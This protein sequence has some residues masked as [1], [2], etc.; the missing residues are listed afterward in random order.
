VA[1]A[2]EITLFA[3]SQL[4]GERERESLVLEGSGSEP[5]FSGLSSGGGQVG[6][7]GDDQHDE[8]RLS[9]RICSPKILF[10][11]AEGGTAQASLG[12]ALQCKG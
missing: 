2:V 4:R 9:A 10:V 11:R 6:G 1:S 8:R 7:L 5:T 12:V 3:P